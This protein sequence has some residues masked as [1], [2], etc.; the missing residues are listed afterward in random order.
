MSEFHFLR[1]LWF[2]A[3]LPALALLVL[4]WR[5][6]ARGGDWQ[7]LVAPALLAHLL[8]DAGRTLRRTPLLLLG[9]GWLLAITALAGPTWQRQ[10]QPV[11]RAPADLVIVLDMS[12]SMAATDLKP[13]RLSQARFVIRDLLAT[14]REGRTALVVFSAEPHVVTP[15]TDDTATIEALLPALAVDIMP[16]RGD[17]AAPALRSA[18][19]LLER[20]GSTHGSVLLLS[21]GSSDPAD[22]LDAVRRLHAQGVRV[23]VIGVGT[24]QGAPVPAAGGGF[25]Q[26]TQGGTRLAQLDE[27]GLRALAASGGGHYQRSDAVQLSRLLDTTSLHDRGQARGTDHGMERW[28]EQ[29]PWLLLPLLVLAAAGFRRGWLGV[30]VVLLVPPPPAHAFGWQD[31]WLRPDQQASR[32]LQQGD[33]RQAAER[34]QDPHWRAAAQYQAGDYETAAQGFGNDGADAAYNR[35]NALAH[36][37]KLQEALDAYDAALAAQPEHADARF[38]RELVEQL[39][40]AQQPP[41]QSNPQSGSSEQQDAGRDDAAEQQQDGDPEQSAQNGENGSGQQNRDH[42]QQAGAAPGSTSSDAN[43]DQD[44][45]GQQAQAAQQPGDRQSA[46]QSGSTAQAGA[47][48]AEQDQSGQQQ[49]DGMDRSAQQPAATAQAGEQDQSGRQQAG[50]TAQSA[51]QATA[52]PARDETN[53]AGN[54]ERATADASGQSG[55]P[56]IAAP[57]TTQTATPPPADSAAQA[58]A[59]VDPGAQPSAAQAGSADSAQPLT[60]QDIAM[61]QWLRQVPDDPA[62]LLRSK[63]MVE[64]L[65]RQKGQT[66]P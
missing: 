28:V 52:Q 24:P 33:A 49:A 43:T 19:T 30:L 15:L 47:Q 56:E 3:L 62:G 65:L 64:H 36:A 9:L 8:L 26:D 1:P 13:D 40:Q 53:A 11:F 42:A 27:S 25:E 37:G 5:Q 29:G 32:L 20:V 12:A 57:D 48:P 18:G 39:L 50:E 44:G 46:Q 6:R 41:P 58:R 16:V 31:L 10:P 34:F 55:Q 54:D 22:S 38:N 61:E 45:A 2:A 21:D 66:T 59:D 17:R 63:F 60:E 4:L 14:Q 51:P 7:Q 35:G 23:S